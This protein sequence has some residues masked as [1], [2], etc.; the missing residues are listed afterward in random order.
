MPASRSRTDRWRDCLAQIRDRRGGIEI[1]VDHGIQ[2]QR[3][4]HNAEIP[5]LP[6]LIWRVR[7]Y[8]VEQARITVEQPGALGQ[9]I[10]LPVGTP[11]IAALSVGQNRWMFRTDVQAAEGDTLRLRLPDTVERCTR[12]ARHRIPT[13]ELTLPDVRCWMLRDPTTAAQ[14]EDANRA[15]FE[16]VRASGRADGP[17]KADDLDLD[18][19]PAGVDVG[20]G[21][22][23]RMANIGGGGLGLIVH[24][25]QVGAV[26]GTRLYYTRLDLRPAM[27]APL[28][29]TV[30]MAHT[31]TDS[32]QMLHAGVAFEFGINPGHQA[33]VIEQIE[34][35][36]DHL[37]QTARA[38]AA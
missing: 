34:R 18:R 21:F 30:R 8:E 22:R 24:P 32:S 37:R 2:P 9:R 36:T 5:A 19:P 23:A 27:P 35:Y 38:A 25:D 3:F 1:A 7:L 11:L 17:D 10:R 14:A 26:A 28:E 6:D 31:H 29:M 15:A 13:A 12:R 16:A 4:A 20:S 33:F